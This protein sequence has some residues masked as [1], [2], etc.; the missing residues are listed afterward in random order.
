MKTEKSDQS[1]QE[2]MNPNQVDKALSQILMRIC[3]I[4]L[5]F[6]SLFLSLIYLIVTTITAP[7]K[8]VLT[9]KIGFKSIWLF[10][11]KMANFACNGEWEQGWMIKDKIFDD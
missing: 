11:D 2:F 3:R 7:I 4:I 6:I 5:F 1:I 8:W 9:G 10:I